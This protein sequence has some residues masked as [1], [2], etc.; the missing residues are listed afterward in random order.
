[1]KNPFK[2]PDHIAQAHAKL[3]AAR[4]HFLHHAMQERY[5]KHITEYFADQIQFYTDYIKEHTNEPNNKRDV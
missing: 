5:H 2:S 4:Q 3:E 1:M